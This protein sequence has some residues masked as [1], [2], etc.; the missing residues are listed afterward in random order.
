[1][2]LAENPTK[3]VLP[4]VEQAL[5]VARHEEVFRL[6][7][8]LT[9]L[10]DA[11]KDRPALGWVFHIQGSGE[12][13]GGGLLN[14]A[15]KRPLT[16]SRLPTI[17]GLLEAFVQRLPSGGLHSR[18][19]GRSRVNDDVRIKVPAPSIPN[20]PLALECTDASLRRLRTNHVQKLV[21]VLG[22]HLDYIFFV[23]LN[24]LSDSGR[25]THVCVVHALP[26]LHHLVALKRP[27]GRTK[28]VLG[29]IVGLPG[30]CPCGII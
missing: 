6:T 29:D 7:N 30:L 24:D 4:T 1:M 15:R 9:E 25:S 19:K 18:K 28:L 11:F 13:S 20:Y 26:A 23:L 17:L 8:R 10:V 27:L 21:V 2:I 5:K 3:D 14:A 12:P 16:E 22:H